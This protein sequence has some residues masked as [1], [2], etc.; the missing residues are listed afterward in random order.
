MTTTLNAKIEAGFAR[1]VQLLKNVRADASTQLAAAVAA[2]GADIALRAQIDDA[3]TGLATTW[4]SSKIA[5]E[6]GAAMAAL[7]AGA[8]EAQDTLKELADRIVALAQADTGLVSA[9]AVQALTAAQQAQARANIG[10]QSAA[11]LA[12]VLGDVA[13]ADFVAG[14]NA[15]YAAA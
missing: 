13:T 9:A 12:A 1:V 4:S 5:Q 11:D 15:A 3:A 7:V 8:P 6:I 10:A 2:L 14:I